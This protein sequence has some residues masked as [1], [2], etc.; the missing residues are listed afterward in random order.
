MIAIYVCIN[1][2]Y[3]KVSDS[4]ANRWLNLS[5][6]EIFTADISVPYNE[7][8]RHAIYIMSQK[9]KLNITDL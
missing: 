2:V 4:S 3:N 5:T 1:V 9:R 6:F 7:T 8:L